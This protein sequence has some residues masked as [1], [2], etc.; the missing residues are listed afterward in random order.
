MFSGGQS[1]TSMPR[2][3]PMAA[4]MA[5]VMVAKKLAG[6]YSRYVIGC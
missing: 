5:I 3:K 2:C 1:G 4:S 6:R